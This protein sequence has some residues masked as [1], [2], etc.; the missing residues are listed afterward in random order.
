MKPTD[1]NP[2]LIEP[3]PLPAQ[4]RKDWIAALRSGKYR[5]THEY[6]AHKSGYCCMGVAGRV[7]GIKRVSM[8]QSGLLSTTI[9]PKVCKI[10]PLDDHTDFLAETKSGGPATFIELLTDMNDH[11][12]WKFPQIADWLERNTVGV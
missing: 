5:Q 3:V 10:P 1:F 7:L 11:Y 8:L 12:G 6:L 9:D 2:I 4:F